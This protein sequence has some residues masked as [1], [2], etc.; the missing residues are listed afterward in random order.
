[1][2]AALMLNLDVLRQQGLLVVQVLAVT[3]LPL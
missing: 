1:M 2:A 3:V